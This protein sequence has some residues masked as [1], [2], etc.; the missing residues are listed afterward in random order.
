MDSSIK[1]VEKVFFGSLTY[2]KIWFLKN[3]A[4]R[5]FV[6]SGQTGSGIIKKNIYPN[7][8]PYLAYAVGIFQLSCIVFEI[9]ENNIL[10]ERHTDRRNQHIILDRKWACWKAI[11]NVLTLCFFLLTRQFQVT[12][13]CL[14]CSI[15]WRW[16]QVV[17]NCFFFF[18]YCYFL[19]VW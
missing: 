4:G 5:H 1:F 10:T 2:I 7:A 6:F 8:H 18:F 13:C 19:N 14:Y 15:V 16:R 9:W 11:W 17:V 3:R 12:V